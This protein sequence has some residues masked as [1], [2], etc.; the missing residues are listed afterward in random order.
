[1]SNAFIERD[2]YYYGY[3]YDYGYTDGSRS[4]SLKL[5][6]FEDVNQAMNTLYWFRL[7]NGLENNTDYEEPAEPYYVSD[8][9]PYECSAD[10]QSLVSFYLTITSMH[11]FDDRAR[12]LYPLLDRVVAWMDTSY[13]AGSNVTPLAQ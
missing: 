6:S 2:V 5:R 10:T 12:R 7:Y 3:G 11:A 8:L 13:G 1:M 9:G 4:R